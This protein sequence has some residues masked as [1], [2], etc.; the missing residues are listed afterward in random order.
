MFENFLG[1][2]QNELRININQD[3]EKISA[4]IH[5]KRNIELDYVKAV[6]DGWRYIEFSKTAR[7]EILEK[8]NTDL[9]AFY[10]QIKK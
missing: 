1:Y 2:I 9:N 4:E 3:P 5:I 6:F 10:E 8:F 7:K